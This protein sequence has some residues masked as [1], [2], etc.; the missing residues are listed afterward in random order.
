MTD[1]HDL[2]DQ[3]L[4]WRRQAATQTPRVAAALV[5]AAHQL[6]RQADQLERQPYACEPQLK[7][8]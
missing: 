4:Q 6:E 1:P 8:A 5:L 3:A 7:P 2:R